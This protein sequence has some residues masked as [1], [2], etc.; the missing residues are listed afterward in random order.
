LVYLARELVRAFVDSVACWV[1]SL[2]S[3]ENSI[4]RAAR[5][6]AG[7]ALRLLALGDFRF[8]AAGFSLAPDTRDVTV[9]VVAVHRVVKLLAGIVAAREFRELRLM[10]GIITSGIARAAET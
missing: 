10:I 9:I 7:A 5:R 4:D 8:T 2:L 1:T 3:T 6:A